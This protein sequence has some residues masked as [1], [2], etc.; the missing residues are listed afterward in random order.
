MPLP[1]FMLMLIAGFVLLRAGWKVLGRSLCLVAVIGLY[2]SSIAPMAYL[3]SKPLEYAYPPYK[4]QPVD[5]VIVLGGYHRSDSRV[6][7]TSLLSSTSMVRLSEGVRIL[8]A[9]PNAYLCLSGFGGTDEISNAEAMSRVAQQMGVAEYRIVLQES[10]QD[11]RGEAREWSQALAGQKVALVTSAMHLPRAMQLFSEFGM[12][13]LPAP[14]NFRSGAPD[15]SYWKNWIPNSY[16]LH[17]VTA[18]WHE[19][20][21]S[22][23]AHL[24]SHESKGV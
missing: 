23:W 3:V 15:L 19:Y 4:A 21:G 13:P 9:N 16:S 7:I 8:K 18:A 20:L 10:P 17:T 14:T 6:P 2:L 11:T 24:Q 22:A 5:A 1:A 12:R